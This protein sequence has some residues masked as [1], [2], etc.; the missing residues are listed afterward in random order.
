M[1]TCKRCRRV[2]PDGERYC[3]FHKLA[4]AGPR[5][6]TMN[7]REWLG[8]TR[9]WFL[10][11]LPPWT[12]RKWY[13]ITA[14]LALFVLPISAYFW[15]DKLVAPVIYWL[16][17][18][19]LLAYT[20]ETYGL[21]VQMIRQNEIA[22]QPLLILSIERS[23]VPEPGS[24]SRSDVLTVRNIGRGTAIFVQIEEIEILVDDSPESLVVKFD[25]VDYVEPGKSAVAAAGFFSRDGDSLKRHFDFLPNL[26]PKYARER[27]EV[28]L[29]YEDVD[30]G[31]RFSV[32][33]MGKPGIRLAPTRHRTSAMIAA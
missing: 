14:V 11:W 15:D 33:Q 17:A 8:W 28:V 24:V 7:P 30:G 5:P 16:T 13:T 6:R 10:T 1:A 12:T 27:I 3:M 9:R 2:V 29:R 20:Y 32:V 4:P 18:A 23:S 25:T 19:F 31:A 21:R 26:N 22:I